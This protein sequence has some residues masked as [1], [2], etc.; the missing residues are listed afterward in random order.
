LSDSVLVQSEFLD[1]R[2][3]ISAAASVGGN[4]DFSQR[5]GNKSD[6]E[7]SALKSLN[8]YSTSTK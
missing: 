2:A 3:A 7:R 6:N 8:R 5:S 1:V 4:G